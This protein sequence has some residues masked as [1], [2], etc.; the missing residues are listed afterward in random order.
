MSRDKPDIVVPEEASNRGCILKGELRS[1]LVVIPEILVQYSKVTPHDKKATI[2]FYPTAEQA[3]KAGGPAF[4]EQNHESGRSILRVLCEEPALSGVEG[5]GGRLIA[6]WALPFTSRTS[7]GKSP[8]NS[9]RRTLI[10]HQFFITSS[11]WAPSQTHHPPCLKME[12]NMIGQARTVSLSRVV[13][14]LQRPFV[15][16]SISPLT[17]YS[18]ILCV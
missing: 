2:H 6:P 7:E 16:Q 4:R 12:A 15:R 11:Q 18:R 3:R 13:D 5:V 1:S 10:A 17:P 9:T 8:T 14:A